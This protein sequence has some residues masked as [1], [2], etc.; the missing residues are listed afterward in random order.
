MSSSGGVEP[1]RLRGTIAVA[2]GVSDEGGWW[3]RR[4]CGRRGRQ[5]MRFARERPLYTLR[6]SR[7]MDEVWFAMVLEWRVECQEEPVSPVWVEM[8]KIEGGLLRL[9]ARTCTRLT[10]AVLAAPSYRTSSWSRGKW[11]RLSWQ[12]THTQMYNAQ[13]R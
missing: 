1:S 8:A 3:G 12:Q 7:A 6:M 13:V 4:E 5:L 2:P 11:P 9:F 10:R